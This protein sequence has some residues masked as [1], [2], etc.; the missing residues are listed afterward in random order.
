MTDE[1][2]AN[3]ERFV[4][5]NQLWLKQRDEELEDYYKNNSIDF[6]ITEHELKTLMEWQHTHL[7]TCPFEDKTRSGSIS[8]TFTRTGIG[9]AIIVS[10]SCGDM[11]N[12]TDYAG[13]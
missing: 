2:W 4:K 1:V 11:K 3:F 6:T 10:C 13:W 9:T 12:I 7:K 5:R 8:Y